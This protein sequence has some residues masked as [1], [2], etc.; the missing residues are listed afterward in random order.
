[1]KKTTFL[2]AFILLAAGIVWLNSCQK[3]NAVQQPQNTT[4][5]DEADN[6]AMLQHILDFKQ[7][8]E[9][10]K[11]H[12]GLRD[13][14]SFTAPDAVYELEA[15]LNFNFCYTGITCNKKEF[16]TTQVTM[17]LD[18]IGEIGESKLAQL[19][20]DEIIDSI[21]ARMLSLTG[22]DNMKLLLVDLKQT[23]TDENGDAIV[24][25]GALVGNEGEVVLHNDNWWYGENAG[26]CASGWYNDE[27][28]ATQL[29]ARV[30]DAMLPE[31]PAGCRWFFTSIDSTY[32]FPQQDTLDYTP[33]N[34]LDYKIFFATTEGGLSIDDEVKCLSMYEMNTYEGYYIDYAQ[35]YE[36]QTGKKFDYCT[37]IGQ[38]YYYPY[39]IQHDYTI[40]AGVRWLEC[41]ANVG[42][43]LAE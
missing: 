22:Y 30:T 23:G 10:C 14:E 24:S 35:E 38:P 15:L 26:L 27:D 2:F 28:A 34:Y 39:H 8:M 40:W 7:R 13:G 43:I 11:A 6:E 18:E 32:I 16:V 9:D 1:M 29:G 12:P 36:T 21:Q 41:D 42:D 17:P 33:D 31:P 37:I 20:Y 25:I 19:Y 4:G 3:E 5:T